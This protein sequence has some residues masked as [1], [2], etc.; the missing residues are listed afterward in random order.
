[1]NNSR[2]RLIS[3]GTEIINATELIEIIITHKLII[4]AH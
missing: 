2:S 1:M 3:N 4:Y